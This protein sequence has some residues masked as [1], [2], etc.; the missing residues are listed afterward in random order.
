MDDHVVN[1]IWQEVTAALTGTPCG[2]TADELYERSEYAETKET[3]MIILRRMAAAL[4]I[5]KPSY[6]HRF[7]LTDQDA[8]PRAPSPKI[9]SRPPVPPAPPPVLA[10][11]TERGSPMKDKLSNKQI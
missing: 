3:L 7:Q 2:L 8:A 11:S 9:N 4:V 1:S 10:P 5:V 6:S